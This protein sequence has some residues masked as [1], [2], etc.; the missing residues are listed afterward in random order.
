MKW[1]TNCLFKHKNNMTVALEVHTS[2]YVKEK[3][4]WSMKV[5]WWNIGNRHP[6]WHMGITQRITVAHK[7]KKDWETYYVFR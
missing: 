5:S 4:S 3:G 7:A 2:F 1:P 6:P